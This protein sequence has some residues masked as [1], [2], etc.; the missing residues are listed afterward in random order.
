[1]ISETSDLELRYRDINNVVYQCNY[2]SEATIT[3]NKGVD[4]GTIDN[5]LTF[6]LGNVIQNTT[7]SD[8]EIDISL[9]DFRFEDLTDVDFTNTKL[10]YLDISAATLPSGVFNLH[11]DTD[12]STVQLPPGSTIS[13]N[14]LIVPN[15]QNTV[16]TIPDGYK[17]LDGKL[18]GQQADLNYVSVRQSINLEGIDLSQAQFK[19]FRSNGSS[20][21]A[22]QLYLGIIDGSR[23]IDSNDQ[24][25]NLPS[26]YK[27]INGYLLGPDVDLTNAA[28][29]QK[30]FNFEGIDLSSATLNGFLSDGNITLGTDDNGE[31][32]KDSD[33]TNIKL[34]TGYIIH[35]GYLIGPNVRIDGNVDLTSYMGNFKKGDIENLE[36]F[37]QGSKIDD[38]TIV[39]T[40]D[41][42]I[43]TSTITLEIQGVTEGKVVFFDTLGVQRSNLV[44]IATVSYLENKYYF[45]PI[46]HMGINDKIIDVKLYYVDNDNDVYECNYNDSNIKLTNVRNSGTFRSGGIINQE[47]ITLPSGYIMKNG[48]I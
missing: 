23:V 48:A 9:T 45:S 25:I 21:N 35:D 16:Q 7:L 24:N 47:N 34:P 33:G 2:E 37:T 11:T 29:R 10:V 43:T 14:Q 41:T 19:G 4:Q 42:M 20:E 12:V 22:G 18:Y 6:T 31:L 26:E 17:L 44:D 38:I 8:S 13:N 40:I 27:I 5:L 28:F 3:L 46:V 36:L 39:E 15:E 32:I 1:M 30:Q